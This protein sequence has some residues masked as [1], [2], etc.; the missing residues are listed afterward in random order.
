MEILTDFDCNI[1]GL[2]Q[3]V[4]LIQIFISNNFRININ[5][6]TTNRTCPMLGIGKMF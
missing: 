1:I 6:E 4:M 2:G 3:V 5:L